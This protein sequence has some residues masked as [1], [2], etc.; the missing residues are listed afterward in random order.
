MTS[1][2]SKTADHGHGFAR[3]VHDEGGSS[4][5]ASLLDFLLRSDGNEPL[6]NIVRLSRPALKADIAHFLNIAFG[7]YPGIVDHAAST[8]NDAAPRAWLDQS[9]AGFAAERAF[10]NRMTVA[11]GP[12]H[13]QIGQERIS[14]TLDALARSMDMLATSERAGCAAGAAI[15]FVM[16]WQETRPLLEHIALSLSLE[17]PVQSLPDTAS[18]LALVDL[19]SANPSIRRAMAFGSQQMLAQQRGLWRI[20]EVRHQSMLSAD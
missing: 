11:A 12:I 10:L 6:R 18:S 16:D 14:A 13:R 19:L 3:G 15:A 17:V 8:I 9:V 20:I 1:I 5:A 4:I 7:R 2:A